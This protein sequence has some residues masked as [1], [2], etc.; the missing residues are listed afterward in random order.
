MERMKEQQERGRL[1]AE[2]ACR[3]AKFPKP[4]LQ[5]FPEKDDVESYL[6]MF[7]RVAAQQEWPTA[8]WAPLRQCL[9]LLLL[10]GPCYCKRL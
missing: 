9:G 4:M 5:K 10:A 3:A 8:R 7:E 1:A 6:D 2:E